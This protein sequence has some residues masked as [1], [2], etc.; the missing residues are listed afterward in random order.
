MQRVSLVPIINDVIQSKRFVV[1]GIESKDVIKYLEQL[2]TYKNLDFDIRN[3]LSRIEPKNEH[4]IRKQLLEELIAGGLLTRDRLTKKQLEDL[5][6]CDLNLNFVSAILERLNSY[7]LSRGESYIAAHRLCEIRIIL[8]CIDTSNNSLELLDYMHR[9]IENLFYPLRSVQ[10]Y[11]QQELKIITDSPK[12]TR[13]KLSIDEGITEEST[14]STQ[15]LSE[16]MSLK[17]KV[18]GE[19]KLLNSHRVRKELLQEL[20]RNGKLKKSQLSEKQLQDLSF[21]HVSLDLAKDFLQGLNNYLLKKGS[22]NIPLHRWDEVLLCLESFKKSTNDSEFI[23]SIS[24]IKDSLNYGVFSWREGFKEEL[25]KIVESYLDKKTRR[26]PQDDFEA[27]DDV[28]DLASSEEKSPEASAA[29]AAAPEQSSAGK[30]LVPPLILDSSS[31]SYEPL[32]G[33]SSPP[34]LVRPAA[35][36]AKKK[37]EDES[38]TRAP[39]PTRRRPRQGGKRH[40]D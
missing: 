32:E 30:R 27:G 26:E 37:G 16:G 10:N 15:L 13:I 9:I 6:S 33:S 7:I 36:A 35:E 4:L 25:D 31:E 3:L 12:F 28:A 11:L 34:A 14:E 17:E 22:V 1:L 20:R 18:C 23:V 39:N 21:S 40:D 29:A 8:D 24:S 2:S 19:I 5:E 38:V